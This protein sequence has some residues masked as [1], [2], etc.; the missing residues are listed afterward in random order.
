MFCICIFFF[1]I[2][3]KSLLFDFQKGGQSIPTEY[4]FRWLTLVAGRRYHQTFR[5]NG[6]VRNRE[7]GYG[8]TEGQLTPQNIWVQ[9]PEGFDRLDETANLKMKV[10]GNT[11]LRS[12]VRDGDDVWIMFQ[13]RKPSRAITAGG[14]RSGGGGKEQEKPTFNKNLQTLQRE[15]F[16]IDSA[17]EWLKRTCRADQ[18]KI[19]LRIAAKFRTM[20]KEQNKSIRDIFVAFDEDGGG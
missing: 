3:P 16:D 13:N 7:S 8:G 5:P 2:H 11:P 10:E 17:R 6:R 18:E 9:M 4:T 1:C 15:Q 20:Q 12:L 14:S 19:Q